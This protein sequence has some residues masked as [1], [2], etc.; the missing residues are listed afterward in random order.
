VISDKF[1]F[2]FFHVPKAAGSSII[3]GINKNC[4]STVIINENN[5]GLKNY[6]QENKHRN[7]PN[8]TNCKIMKDFLGEKAFNNYFKFAFVRNPYDKLVSI[9]H[10]VKQKEAKMFIGKIDQLPKFNQNIIKSNSFEHWVKECNLGD[11]QFSFLTS[12]AGQLLVNYIGKTEHIQADLSYVYGLLKVPNM[13]VSKVNVSKRRDYRSYFDKESIDI[14]SKKFIDD[15]Y[16]FG[17]NFEEEKTNPPYKQ[18][19]ESSPNYQIKVGLSQVRENNKYV[20]IPNDMQQSSM[21]LHTNEVNRPV[22]ETVFSIE[23]TKNYSFDEISFS[24]SAFNRNK[25]NPG[26]KLIVSIYQGENKIVNKVVELQPQKIQNVKL[27]L[28]KLNKCT[29]H[30]SL[31]NLETIQSNKYCGVY[32]SPLKIT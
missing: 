3:D 23:A 28:T 4:P 18:L 2:I 9:Y 27:E 7:W 17:Y 13:Y 19:T 24:S 1:N 20:R 10:Y 14:V 29:I 25:G 11:T 16:F 30:F 6:L 22:L 8:H 26:C 15:I 5:K 21:I 32:I 12:N 31:Q